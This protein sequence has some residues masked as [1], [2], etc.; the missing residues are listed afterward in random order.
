MDKLVEKIRQ[1]VG[2]FEMDDSI[3][4]IL[5]KYYI[6]GKSVK[7]LLKDDSISGWSLQKTLNVKKQ[8]QPI[9]SDIFNGFYD[10]TISDERFNKFLNKL[11]FLF[12][13]VENFNAFRKNAKLKKSLIKLL[14]DGLSFGE[15]IKLCGFI[16]FNSSTPIVITK[17]EPS[18]FNENLQERIISYNK[19]ITMLNTTGIIK[20]LTCTKCDNYYGISC[21]DSIK[22]N[23]VPFIVHIL[24]LNR[25][26]L[27]IDGFNIYKNFI[28]GI[29]L[30]ML[31]CSFKFKKFTEDSYLLNMFNPY[32]KFLDKDTSYVDNT[33]LTTLVKEI[34][35]D[36]FCSD[37]EEINK[38]KIDF[39][40]FPLKSISKVNK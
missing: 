6:D 7:T 18:N 28:E 33:I 8:L 39:K 35:S 10:D 12:G 23:L 37:I 32:M 3:N 36:I 29:H 2:Y 20:R 26:N 15:I 16:F 11:I 17:L 24:L 25:D 40:N 5:E 34:K 31:S 30:K 13:Y 19:F 22:Y 1:S 38:R 21:Y 27:K 9:I 14:N 4:L